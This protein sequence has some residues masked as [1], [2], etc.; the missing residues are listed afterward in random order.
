MGL[1]FGRGCGVGFRVSR[2]RVQH[3]TQAGSHGLDLKVS[4]ICPRSSG[5]GGGREPLSVE[6]RR[7]DPVLYTACY[8]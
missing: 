2:F 1:G 3:A 6:T 8:K 5:D 4:G 7:P